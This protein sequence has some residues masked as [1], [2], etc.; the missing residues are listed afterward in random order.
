MYS[1]ISWEKNTSESAQEKHRQ[2]LGMF[3]SE[4][5]MLD[6]LDPT[7]CWY[8]GWG[9]SEDLLEI[10]SLINHYQK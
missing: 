9:W 7:P 1:L 8:P 6:Q 3:L 5:C 2:I 10:F 4:R